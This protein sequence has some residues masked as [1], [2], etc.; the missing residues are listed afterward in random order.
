MKAAKSL[1]RFVLLCLFAPA[2]LLLGS[3]ATS[4]TRGGLWTVT[5]QLLQ[6]NKMQ[7]LP[8]VSRASCVFPAMKRLQPGKIHNF[9]SSAGIAFQKM[10]RKKIK[11]NKI[12]P[13]VMS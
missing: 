10:S 3:E 7:S 6:S 11:Y 1:R 12:L 5:Q 4:K 8:S 9:T 13:F 2:A